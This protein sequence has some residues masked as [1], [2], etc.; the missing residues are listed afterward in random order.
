MA[1]NLE[2]SAVRVCL[3]GTA[4]KHGRALTIHA[5]EKL[6]KPAAIQVACGPN[7]WPVG[8]RGRAGQTL[9]RPE[10]GQPMSAPKELVQLVG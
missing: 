2:S 1:G 3:R 4:T 7:G 6:P 10:C 5:S 9:P 8:V